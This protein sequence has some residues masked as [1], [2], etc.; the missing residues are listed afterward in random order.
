MPVWARS[1][2]ISGHHFSGV[3]GT[4]LA[5]F[6]RVADGTLLKLSPVSTD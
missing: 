3:F 6:H 4:N 2:G 5:P 1:A